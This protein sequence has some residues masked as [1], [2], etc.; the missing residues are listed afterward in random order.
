MTRQLGSYERKSHRNTKFGQ[1][2]EKMVQTILSKL[3]V[4]IITEI[5]AIGKKDP[6][7]SPKFKNH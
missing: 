4:N 5:T 3:F 6:K 1:V 7:Y 2:V